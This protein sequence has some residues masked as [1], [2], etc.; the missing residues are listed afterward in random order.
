MSEVVSVHID[1]KKYTGWESVE[2]SESM[3]S[4]AMTFNIGL[5]SSPV[6]KGIVPGLP[7]KIFLGSDLVLRG[8][9]EKRTRAIDASS[10]SMSIS[11]RDRLG[12]L[13]DC[14]I[15]K[16]SGSWS[17]ISLLSVCEEIAKPFSVKVLKNANDARLNDKF[18]S[19]TLQDGESP[20]ALIERLCRQRAILPLSNQNGDLVLS[21]PSTV[22][23]DDAMILGVNIKE[24]SEDIDYTNRFATYKIKGQNTGGGNPWKKTS[25]T[26][27]NAAASDAVIKRYRPLI[28][29]AETRM[30]TAHAKQR[31]AWEATV[32]F[33]RSLSLSTT[34]MGWRQTS[35]K[36]WHRNTLVDLIADDFDIDGTFMISA[37]KYKLDSSGSSTSFTLRNR[38]AYTLN[39]K[40]EIEQ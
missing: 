3:E 17:K 40:G 27:I 28:L 22:V 25:A 6:T 15:V 2:I 19:V 30:T 38:L 32:R 10:R 34:V 16:K 18:K 11:G 13:I 14:S 33:G 37:V 12:D 24:L 35:G 36:L 29:Q 23:S 26:G 39:E 21:E 4:A 8:F 1:G 5:V 9:I 31:A 20:F 7:I